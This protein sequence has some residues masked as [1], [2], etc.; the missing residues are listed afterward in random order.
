MK[1]AKLS[2][3]FMIINTIFDGTDRYFLTISSEGEVR[4][5]SS[6]QFSD[7]ANDLG[8]DI[9]IVLPLNK[10]FYKYVEDYRNLDFLSEIGLINK[11]EAELLTKVQQGQ[12]DEIQIVFRDQ[13][14]KQ[15][16]YKKEIKKSYYGL[17][18]KI[19][20]QK[21]YQD[22]VIKTENGDIVY[23]ALVTKNKFN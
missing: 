3:L 13:K 4:D 18:A 2:E 6:S 7:F 20:A 12:Y 22:I 19:V 21:K 14:M 10:F 5:F 17:M 8:Q 9:R 11:N 1:V 23:A 15:A 16:N